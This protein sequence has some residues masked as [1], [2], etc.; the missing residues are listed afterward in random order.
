VVLAAMGDKERRIAEAVE[1]AG[2]HLKPTVVGDLI[3]EIE[4][5]D[6]DAGRVSER[7]LETRVRGALL[8]T[9]LSYAGARYLDAALK[10]PQQLRNLSTPCVLQVL[11]PIL[12][13]VLV[14]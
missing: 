2:W 7:E 14:T 11:L 4:E 1:K 3:R 5:E 6:E 8:D 9:D 12:S 13:L 10:S